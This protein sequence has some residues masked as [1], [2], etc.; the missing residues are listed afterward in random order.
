MKDSINIALDVLGY[1]SIVFLIL[2]LSV[3]GILL[4]KDKT[5]PSSEEENKNTK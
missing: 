3:F 5:D 4:A 1:F 2:F